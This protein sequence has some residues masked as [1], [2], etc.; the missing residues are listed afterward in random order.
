MLDSVY[1]E[2]PG[3]PGSLDTYDLGEAIARNIEG[4]DGIAET[5]DTLPL[6]SFIL[7]TDG[8]YLEAFEENEEDGEGDTPD[9]TGLP[10]SFLAVDG[11]MTVQALLDHLSENPQVVSDQEAIM[12]ELEALKGVLRHAEE[13]NVGF[14][15]PME[16]R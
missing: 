15:I 5:I 6:S 9:T 10:E 13:N 11:L 8:E 4:L 16:P 1:V 7:P 3:D 2:R 14:F 12:S